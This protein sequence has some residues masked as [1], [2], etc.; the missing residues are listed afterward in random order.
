MAMQRSL[1]AAAEATTV[2]LLVF[3]SMGQ[4]N[5]WWTPPL[6]AVVF[7]VML[8]V[9]LP[10]TLPA[11]GTLDLPRAAG[12]LLVGSAAA[13]GC[14][15][16][17]DHHSWARATGAALF[18]LGV[19]APVW[20]RRYGPVWR[21]GGTIAAL[22]FLAVLVQ[23]LPDQNSW[24][25]L[26]WMLV[27]AGI[28]Y[29]W[30]V[31]IHL[32]SMPNPAPVDA[33]TAPAVAPS[34]G[35]R[36]LPASTRMAIQLTLAVGAAFA[37]G[38][39]TDHDHL[40]WPVLTVLVVH[41]ANRGRGDVLWKGIE[42]SIGALAGTLVAT[43]LVGTLAAGDSLA[44]VVIFAI[45][46]LAAA[47]REISYASRAAA[48]T[49]A[50]AFLYGYFG[51]GGTSLLT[52]RLLGVSGGAAIGMA[53]AW[54]VPVRTTDATRV[55]TAALLAAATDLACS[56]S[57]GTPDQNARLRLAA[58]DRD[59]AALSPTLRAA[60]RFGRG[61]ARQL[62]HT[63]THARAL[64]NQAATLATSTSDLDTRD[65][66]TAHHEIAALL[67]QISDAR[68]ALRDPRRVS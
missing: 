36:R 43:L 31:A 53:A 68:R 47:L 45:L 24:S 48:T 29:A 55:R 17:L 10:R 35:S 26:G 3:W 14:A 41:S 30:A 63:V 44:I 59:L 25:F 64:A 56:A 57:A 61:P 33:P 11:L 9:G 2:L 13:V 51:Q 6:D 19:A 60:R 46:A 39:W 66:A 23:P 38:Q 15:M 37:F 12:A 22:P 65:Q 49:A 28:A 52:H 21:A 42:R 62:D 54:V 40:V 16:L 58:A 27:G 32:L 4:L 18:T 20:L 34:A 50:L 5:T 67:D 1:R 7:A 8:A